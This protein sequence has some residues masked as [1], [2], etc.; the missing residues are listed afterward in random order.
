MHC[1]SIAILSS[2]QF[3]ILHNMG[4]AIV[5]IPD[6]ARLSRSGATPVSVT[7]SWQDSLRRG[8]EFYHPISTNAGGGRFVVWGGLCVCVYE[9]SQADPWKW[10]VSEV[11]VMRC[12]MRARTWIAHLGAS[13]GIDDILIWGTQRCTSFAWQFPE[14]R[15]VA[16]RRLNRVQGGVV[17]VGSIGG[18]CPDD[19]TL[20]SFSYDEESGMCIA[21]AKRHGG[22]EGDLQT[23]RVM[24]LLS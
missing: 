20:T 1:I 9:R 24:H 16:V 6:P 17:S 7:P 14:D 22:H 23:L 3:A 4:V 21:V 10:S 2:S 8:C 11:R 5:D 15:E 12:T 13:S 19:H 18:I